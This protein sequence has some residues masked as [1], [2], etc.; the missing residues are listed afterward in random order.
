MD[1]VLVVD[2]ATKLEGVENAE[3]DIFLLVV[4]MV[5]LVSVELNV[6]VIR[7]LHEYERNKQEAK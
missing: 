7:N 6:V 2:R 5:E 3:E 1:I 4:L